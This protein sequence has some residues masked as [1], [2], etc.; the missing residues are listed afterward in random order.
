MPPS[1]PSVK[2]GQVVIAHG[3]TGTFK[4]LEVSPDGQTADIQPF[5]LSKQAAF[6]NIKEGIPSSTLIPYEE[7]ANSSIRDM[8]P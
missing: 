4:V 8:G 6:G 7:D 2:K 1:K 5:S 3:N